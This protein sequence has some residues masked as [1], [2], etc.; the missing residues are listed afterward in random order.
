MK[1]LKIKKFGVLNLIALCAL[2]LV[3]SAIPTAGLVIK[4]NNDIKENFFGEASLL[5]G[6]L[7]I[8]NIDTFEAGTDSKESYLATLASTFEEENKGT[9]VVI[10]NITPAELEINL[11]E[12]KHP[13]LYSFGYGLGEKLASSLSPLE[14]DTWLPENIT[15]SSLCDGKLL[16]VPFMVGGYLVISSTEKLAA[17]QKPEDTNLLAEIDNLGYTKTLRKKS[18]EVKSAIYGDSGFTSAVTVL[19]QN[20]ITVSKAEKYGDG[21]NAYVNYMSLG[22]STALIGSQRDLARILHKRSLGKLEEGFVFAPVGGYTD[23]I[24]SMG[25]CRFSDE[26]KQQY[27]KKFLEFCLTETNQKRLS[28]IGMFSALA[29]KLYEEGEFAVLE[30]SLKQNLRLADIYKK[31]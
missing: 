28:S 5:Q 23:L 24:Q 29:I 10:K 12:G 14:L 3:L 19:A 25:I 20:G 4:K 15:N 8:W 6:V 18:I 17:A 1:K 26:L 7:E 2:V 30:D 11:A 13:D 16:S 21:Y 31:I 22:K 27:A 9:Y